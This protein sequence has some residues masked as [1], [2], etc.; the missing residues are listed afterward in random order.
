MGI[1][2]PLKCNITDQTYFFLNQLDLINNNAHAIFILIIKKG[3]FLK[4]HLKYLHFHL[5]VFLMDL[6]FLKL[7]ILKNL[8]EGCEI[9]SKVCP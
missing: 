7:L 3:A 6:T 2:A 9:S 1:S 8:P 4:N 5:S